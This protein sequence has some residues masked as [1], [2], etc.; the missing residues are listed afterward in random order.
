MAGIDEGG[1]PGGLRI[2]SALGM[3]GD[4]LIKL[5]GELDLLSA[6]SLRHA[7]AAALESRPRRLVFELSGLR[8]ID[9]AGLAVL[10]EA[11]GSVDLVELRDPSP[12][13][14]RAVELTGL[15]DVLRLVG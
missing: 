6:D 7:I 11:S 15:A 3:D 10:I 13:V 12:A 2:D 5:T 14:R 4:P 8:F 1:V 9:S